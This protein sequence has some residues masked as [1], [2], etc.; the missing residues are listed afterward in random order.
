MKIKELLKKIIRVPYYYVPPCPFCG[1][2]MTGR[3]LKSHW[4]ADDEYV[5]DTSLK[6][7]E[8]V[9][10]RPE[11]PSKNVFCVNCGHDWT[12]YIE[13]RFMT[14]EEID[15]E[16]AARSTNEIRAQEREEKK[17]KKKRGVLHTIARFIGHI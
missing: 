4:A 17:G 2:K 1:S 10:F 13:S 11:I 9:V 14:L 3:Y 8:L 7:G 16:K 6:N 5:A 15:K 12:E